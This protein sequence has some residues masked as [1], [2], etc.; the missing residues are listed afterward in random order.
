[1][2]SISISPDTYAPLGRFVESSADGKRAT[3]CDVIASSGLHPP[4]ARK[5]A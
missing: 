4:F 1:M 2:S 5:D 3:P